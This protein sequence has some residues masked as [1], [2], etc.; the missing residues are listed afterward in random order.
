MN[1]G[2]Y[3]YLARTE[4]GLTQAE[5]GLRSDRSQSEIARL[6]AGRVRTSFETVRDLVRACGLELEFS[7]ARADDSYRGEIEARLAAP[8]AER[9]AHGLRQAHQAQRLQ[10]S[11]LVRAAR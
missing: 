7:F 8:P 2:D 3:V 10:G 4:A 9:V 5:L 6:E 1:G 11:T